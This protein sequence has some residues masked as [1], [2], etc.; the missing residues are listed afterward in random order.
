MASVATALSQPDRTFEAIYLADIRPGLMKER[1][2]DALGRYDA[3]IG[4][5]TMFNGGFVPLESIDEKLLA[6]FSK[7]LVNN[8]STD[9]A[10][11]AIVGTVRNVVR[12]IDPARCNPH[13]GGRPPAPAP[14]CKPGTLREFFDQRYW[15]HKTRGRNAN[16]LRLYNN[17][18]T[19]F[20][21]CLGRPPLLDDLTD[22]TVALFMAWGNAL[23]I[24]HISCWIRE[25][26]PRGQ[27][28]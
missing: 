3:V 1:S 21:K 24:T 25:P 6:K 2:P 17:M 23:S 7:W 16:N 27:V 4:R 13:Q 11:Y 10:A 18:L 20:A 8:G 5:F 15:P 12:M 19:N 28:V 26:G 9:K 22:E 14:E